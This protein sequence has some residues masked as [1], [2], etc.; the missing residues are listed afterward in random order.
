MAR[1]AMERGDGWNTRGYNDYRG[2]SVVGAWRWVESYGFGIAA[3]V[4]RDA[5]FT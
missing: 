3:E 2:V 4:D 1:Q 5:A